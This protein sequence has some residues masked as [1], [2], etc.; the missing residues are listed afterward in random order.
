MALLALALLMPW[1]AKARDI[2][3]NYEE[4]QTRALEKIATSLSKMEGY[5]K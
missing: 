4:R 1:K 3:N 2:E 5:C